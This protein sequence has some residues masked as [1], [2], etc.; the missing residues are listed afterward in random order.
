LSLKLDQR[1]SGGKLPIVVRADSQ[2]VKQIT[3]RFFDTEKQII[4]EK[5]LKIDFKEEGFS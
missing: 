4:H 3:I 1:F 2:G 5:I